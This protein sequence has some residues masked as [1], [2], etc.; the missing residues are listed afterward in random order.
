M[1]KTILHK[2]ERATKHIRGV[3]NTQKGS[4]PLPSVPEGDAMANYIEK[5][6]EQ[7]TT[8]MN[9][10]RLGAALIT[11]GISEAYL[12]WKELD[13]IRSQRETYR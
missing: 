3:Y 2:I 13:E 11:L 8:P 1:S 5:L 4:Y 9:W 6:S 10:S 7:G 12:K